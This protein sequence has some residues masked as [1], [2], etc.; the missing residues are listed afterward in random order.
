MRIGI[1][2]PVEINSLKEYLETTSEFELSLG[3]GGTAVNLIILGLLGQGHSVVV[4]TLDPK[5][6]KKLVLRGSNLKIIIGHFR[7]NSKLKWFDF[8]QHEFKQIRH[9]IEEEKRNLDIVNAHWSYE[10]AI[11]TILAKVPHLITF[12]DHARTVLKM[13]NYHPYRFFR[14]LMDAWVRKNGEN[15]SFNSDYL[16]RSIVLKNNS[17]KP[18]I[19]NPYPSEKIKSYRKYP[20]KEIIDIA[21]IAN[22]WDYL[23]NPDNAIQ[24]FIL[25]KDQY[26]D[27]RLHMYG[28]GYEGNTDEAKKYSAL[29]TNNSIIFHGYYPY[30]LLMRELDHVDILIHTSREES[31]GNNLIEAMANG[32]PVIGGKGSGAVPW[33]LDNG[34]AGI[35]VDV[36]NITEISNALKKLITDKDLYENLSKSGVENIKRRFTVDMVTSQYLE[37]YNRIIN[38]N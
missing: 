30:N 2:A 15:F 11:G 21:F 3:L 29:V 13:K 1:A 17:Q 27:K 14:L 37:L 8:C 24:A 18:V 38:G 10:F 9:F 23:K 36:E 7:A 20:S 25:I 16:A 26:P 32:I 31:F 35:L 28:R 5:I 12:R 19:P 34:K 33:V 6:K 4:F 22:S